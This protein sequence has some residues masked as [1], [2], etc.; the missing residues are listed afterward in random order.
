MTDT[1]PIDL[2]AIRAAATGRIIVR[3]EGDG[4]PNHFSYEGGPIAAVALDVLQLFDEGEITLEGDDLTI[5]PFTL[6]IV[7]REPEPSG[8]VYVEKIK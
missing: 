6:R 8:V 1:D 4:Q 7:A 3:R 5:G 2:E